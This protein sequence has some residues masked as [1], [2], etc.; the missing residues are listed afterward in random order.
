ML[1]FTAALSHY[2]RKEMWFSGFED[3]VFKK[4]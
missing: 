3:G 2:S 4:I 1:D